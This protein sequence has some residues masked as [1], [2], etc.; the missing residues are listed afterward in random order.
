MGKK[1][2]PRAQRSSGAKKKRALKIPAN[3]YPS[4]LADLLAEAIVEQRLDDVRRLLQAGA[5][6]NYREDPDEATLLMMVAET[7]SLELVRL[8]VEAG[9]DVNV[10]VCD[11]P[12]SAL[13]AAAVQ[14]HREVFD[15]L[16]ARTDPLVVKLALRCFPVKEK[17][18]AKDPRGKELLRAASKG[19]VEATRQLLAAGVDANFQEQGESALHLSALAGHLPVVQLLLEAGADP[20]LPTREGRTALLLARTPEIARCL[21]EAGADCQAEDD[22]GETPL[23]TAA[24]EG[25]TDVMRECLRRG[26]DVN[27][28][29]RLGSAVMY[30][31]G[32][33]QTDALRLLAEAGADLTR[34]GSDLDQTALQVGWENERWDF[35]NALADLGAADPGLVGLVRAAA[36]GQVD[37]VRERLRQGVPVD[38][39]LFVERGASVSALQ[40]AAERGH[41]EVVQALLTAGAD[42]NGPPPGK[43][44]EESP[45]LRAIDRGH[46][47]VV[48]LLAAAGADVQGNAFD[49]PLR[50]A[51]L[52]GKLEVV[53][54]LIEAG[55]DVNAKGLFGETPLKL[56]RTSGF[57]EIA[58][59]LRQAGAK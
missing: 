5:D 49:P 6:V 20:N 4:Q 33:G 52:R 15:W 55:A 32:R 27:A 39:R 21:I 35:V 2:T 23:M 1:R 34:R 38:A 31:A 57:K 56:A 7:G 47:A 24:A 25:W 37:R 26:A 51:V 29:S 43:S 13:A 18:A 42:P 48:R 16:A 14:G 50:S 22:R 11:T 54:T 58:K 59:A 36:S 3:A 12:S 10:E 53:Q 8:L 28:Q 40:V 41:A 45:L 9:A 19:N 44:R 30:A 17:K 46:A